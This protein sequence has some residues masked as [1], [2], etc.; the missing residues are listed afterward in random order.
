[1]ENAFRS[2]SNSP[3][4]QDRQALPLQPPRYPSNS[5]SPD[6]GYDYGDSGPSPEGSASKEKEDAKE[7]NMIDALYYTHNRTPAGPEAFSEFDEPSEATRKIFERPGGGTRAKRPDQP[8]FIDQPPIHVNDHSS[9][10]VAT[11]SVL[12]KSRWRR[13]RSRSPS[14]ALNTFDKSR[15][16]QVMLQWERE[17]RDIDGRQRLILKSKFADAH[18]KIE[19]PN[20]ITWQ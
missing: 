1:M 6:D 11:G 3:G 17:E 9:S 10:P 15:F 5:L 7:Q 18:A 13:R 8:N 14:V 12:P 19:S 20:H 16:R 2:R 4:Q